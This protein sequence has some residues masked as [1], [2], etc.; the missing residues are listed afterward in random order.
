MYLLINCSFMIH[1]QCIALLVGWL[2]CLF[3][4]LSWVS[5]SLFQ[6]FTLMTKLYINCSLVDTKL[7]CLDYLLDILH[8]IA[9]CGS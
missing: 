9:L 1:R 7:D 8:Y 6:R 5:S 2:Y 4:H 3:L